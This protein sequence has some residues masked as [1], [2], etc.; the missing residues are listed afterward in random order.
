MH[1]TELLADWLPPE[2]LEDPVR[3]LIEL[4][5]SELEYEVSADLPGL[6]PDE[7]RI[8]AGPSFL[9]LEADHRRVSRPRCVLFPPRIREL[10]VSRHFHLEALVALDDADAT[11]SEGRLRVHLPKAHGAIYAPRPQPAWR[12]IAV[13][14]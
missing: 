4:N 6:A 9:R 1:A 3:P 7:V 12:S 11:L 13:H 5:E 14:H 10:R 8:V 2:H